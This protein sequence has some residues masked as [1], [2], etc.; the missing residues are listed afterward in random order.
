MHFT[1]LPRLLRGSPNLANG[2][3]LPPPP[4]STPDTTPHPHLYVAQRLRPKPPET[5]FVMGP[6]CTLPV[7]CSR[8]QEATRAL[9]TLISPLGSYASPTQEPEDLLAL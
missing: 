2:I 5:A 7:M 4:C 8:H 9:D 6:S 3:L 1:S